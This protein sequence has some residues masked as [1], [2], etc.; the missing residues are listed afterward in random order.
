M[1]P[2]VPR[3]LISV[4]KTRT[5]DL[6]LIGTGEVEDGSGLMAVFVMRIL[7]SAGLVFT[8][9]K[10]NYRKSKTKKSQKLRPLKIES[11]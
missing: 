9:K 3:I 10:S 2:G 8:I 7:I 11:K 1:I 5:Q 6:L 4:G